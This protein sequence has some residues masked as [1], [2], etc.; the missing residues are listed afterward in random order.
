MKKVF[1]AKMMRLPFLF[2]FVLMLMTFPSAVYA[3]DA[4][5]QYGTASSD[6]RTGTQG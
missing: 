2:A 6:G 5:G 4:G 3:E 1:A